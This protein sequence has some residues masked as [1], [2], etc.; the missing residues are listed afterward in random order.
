MLDNSFQLTNKSHYPADNF[1]G[2]QLHTLA[3]RDSSI[4][5]LY[6]TFKQLVPGRKKPQANHSIPGYRLI[7]LEHPSMSF[8]VLLS[9]LIVGR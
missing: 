3:D 1:K 7:F 6:A 2:T 4:G 8:T 5:Y 9:F